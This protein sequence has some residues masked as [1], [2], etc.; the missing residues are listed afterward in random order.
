MHHAYFAT[1]TEATQLICI[2][3]VHAQALY[4]YGSSSHRLQYTEKSMQIHA[5]SA[6]GVCALV[7]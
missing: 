2:V 1:P 3:T 5:H 7:C 6:C 4:R